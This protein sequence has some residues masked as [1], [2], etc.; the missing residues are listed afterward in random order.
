MA[1][2]DPVIYK[3][4]PQHHLHEHVDGVVD[5]HEL[6]GCV[7]E[8]LEEHKMRQ[9]VGAERTITLIALCFSFCAE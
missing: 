5:S 8:L 6:Y 9:Q 2:C 7:E 1:V 4:N 3:S